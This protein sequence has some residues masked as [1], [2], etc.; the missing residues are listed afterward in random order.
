[1][2]S[3]EQADPRILGTLRSAD[4]KGIARIEDQF[5]TDINDLWSALTD[6]TRLAHWLGEFT[7]DLHVGGTF[8]AHFFSSGA[9]STGRV[10]TC[11]PPHHFTVTTKGLHA[12]NEHIVEATLSASGAGTTLVIEQRGLRLDW[13]PAFAAGLQIHIEDLAAHLTGGDRCDSDARMTELI[14]AYEALTIASESS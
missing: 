5:A 11:E 4:G 10:D 7:G 3:K 13:L 1:M 2:T 6:P 9:E 12:P 14:P 8:D